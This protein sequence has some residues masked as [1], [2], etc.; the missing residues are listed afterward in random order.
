VLAALALVVAVFIPHAAPAEHMETTA[1][2]TLEKV[3]AALPSLPSMR[4]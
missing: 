1:K 3:A 2:L 4:P